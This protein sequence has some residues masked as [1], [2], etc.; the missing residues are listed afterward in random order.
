MKLSLYEIL[1]AER[2]LAASRP[3]PKTQWER[4]LVPIDFSEASREALKLAVMLAADP[5][6][7]ITLVHVVEEDFW[8]HRGNAVMMTMARSAEELQHDAGDAAS[9]LGRPGGG[10]GHQGGDRGAHR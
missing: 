4:I 8:L 6:D 10:P 3:A 5:E 9:A 7:R 1:R 2:E